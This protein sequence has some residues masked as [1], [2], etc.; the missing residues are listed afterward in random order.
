MQARKETINLSDSERLKASDIYRTGTGVVDK[1]EYEL[2]TYPTVKH[3]QRIPSKSSYVKRPY[4]NPERAKAIYLQ[5]SRG[6]YKPHTGNTN[7]TY[8]TVAER[9]GD[10]Y[11]S[12]PKNSMEIGLDDTRQDSSKTLGVNYN[13]GK[14]KFWKKAIIYG[15]A[16]VLGLSAACLGV[17]NYLKKSNSD[18]TLIDSVQVSGTSKAYNPKV[19]S[20]HY[21][22]SRFDKIPDTPFMSVNKIKK[23]SHYSV[24]VL[25]EVVLSSPTN[26]VSEVT[27]NTGIN[28]VVLSE[29]YKEESSDNSESY[30]NSVPVLEEVVLSSP[31]NEVSEVSEVTGNTGTNGVVLSESYKEESSDNMMKWETTKA[32]VTTNSYPEAQQMIDEVNGFGFYGVKKDAL[33]KR[34]GKKVKDILGLHQYIL[35]ANGK[36]GVYRIDKESMHRDP[37]QNKKD[38]KDFGQVWNS[39]W[40]HVFT[41]RLRTGEKKRLLDYLTSTVSG[42]WHATGGNVVDTVS[43][44]WGYG[45]NKLIRPWS[46]DIIADVVNSPGY[47]VGRLAGGEVD[48]SC[49]FNDDIY[50]PALAQFFE[51]MKLKQEVPHTQYDANFDGK[52]SIGDVTGWIP[53]VSQFRQD[54]W[55]FE[56]KRKFTQDFL[57][58]LP[59]LVG[60][61]CAVGHIIGDSGAATQTTTIGGGETTT[62]GV[63]SGSSAIIGGTSGTSSSLTTIGSL[64]PDIGAFY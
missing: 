55:K 28:E 39:N 50:A 47:L 1:I 9:K 46:G 6:R 13:T 52:W 44:G 34:V 30:S 23:K 31:T 35:N 22:F 51:D 14:K 7:I 11:D 48:G 40:R 17:S 38:I 42:A 32:E 25:E 24:P 43:E 4:I 33:Y 27:G 20:V 61:K 3:Q 26:E 15:T 36:S 56:G 54:H 12:G 60:A 16:A 37:E 57:E 2:P 8:Q 41:T 29:S 10:I 49:A 53:V 59:F 63:G 64:I 5:K 45:V 18:K 62:S 19:E 58:T 21:D